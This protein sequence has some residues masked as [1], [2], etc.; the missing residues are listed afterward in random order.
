[1]LPSITA[2]SINTSCA[3]WSQQ[4][5]NSTCGQSHQ[6]WLVP[7]NSPP[8][9]AVQLERNLRV[10]FALGCSRSFHNSC[11]PTHCRA[12]SQA[13]G[14]P[15]PLQPGRSGLGW[16][17]HLFLKLQYQCGQGSPGNGRWHSN[18]HLIRPE[19]GMGLAGRF[20]WDEW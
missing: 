16:V 19:C 10:A 18:L 3:L 9:I 17:S 13:P 7:H 2:T 6:G 12:G 11:G 5:M 1:M 4:H 20:S 15:F 8:D 14:S